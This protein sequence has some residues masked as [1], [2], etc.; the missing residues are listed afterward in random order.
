MKGDRLS[1]GVRLAASPRFNHA[2]LLSC[3]PDMA[4]NSQQMS[5]GPARSSASLPAPVARL[6]GAFGRL[7]AN[8]TGAIVAVGLTALALRIVLMPVLG[9][10][11][12]QFHDE[13][14]YLLAADTFAHG[15]LTNPT[16]PKWVHFET[17]HVIHQPSYSSIYPPAQGLVLAA[18]QILGH[19]WIGQWLITGLMCA[20]ICWMLQGW[21]P[22][23]W[24]LY[25]A[26][27]ALLQV[28]VLHYWM[29]SYWSGSVVA[30]GGALALGAL[31]RIK[32]GARIADAIWLAAGVAILA[33]SR[34]YEGLILAL[35]VAVALVTWMV[36]PDGPGAKVALGRIVVPALAVL[37]VTAL[38]SGH[39][40]ARVTGSP[41]RTTYQVD[42]L[43]YNPV[44]AFLWQAP[45][46]EP[47]YHHPTLRRF[48]ELELEQHALHRTLAGFLGYNVYRIRSLWTFYLRGLAS[49]PLLA[50]PWL[51][52]DRRMRFPLI[53]GAVFLF[54]LMC[55]T[56]A[57]PHYAAPATGL[58]FLIVAQCSRR[59]ALWTWRG[60]PLGRITVHPIP[61]LLATGLAVRVAAAAVHSPAELDWPGG[62]LPRAAL[63]D[64][65]EKR[66]GKHLVIVDYAPSH[67]LG[68]E[69]VY[70][71]ADIDA[72]PVVWA[73]SMSAAENREL[74]RYFSDRQSWTLVVNGTAATPL[75][76]YRPAN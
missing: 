43:T 50:L 31:P 23:R 9:I 16:H 76:P 67:D 69:W 51:W 18:G 22:P 48:Y 63:V 24:A 46:P 68:V 25:G 26:A 4:D 44:P 29:N 14:G 12:P 5:S 2:D 42:S 71:A 55:E 39:F 53:A 30:L 7:A 58:V 27:I 38:A 10:P 74:A 60:R 52:R 33:N 17:F 13:F 20:A 62:N 6:S 59:M 65:L 64:E 28:A 3:S 47:T 8:R 75:T 73:R 15:R 11:R 66:P 40:Y 54:A 70:N 56:W 72:S 34:P 41:F 49:L 19:P 45:L 21:L 37:L 61:V 36:G 1:V 32:R 57:L 35:V